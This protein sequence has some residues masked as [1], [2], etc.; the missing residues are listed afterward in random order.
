MLKEYPALGCCG[1][2][3]GLCPSYYTDGPSR[4][5]GCC[6]EDFF[7]KH[8]SCSFIT[9]CVKKKG[10]KVCAQCEDFPCTKFDHASDGP[11]FKTTSK[12][13]LQNQQYIRE[14]GLDKFIEQQKA[15]IDLLQDMLAQYNDGKAKTFY[16]LT[17]TLLSFEGL[18]RAFNEANN[19]VKE[20]SVDKDDLRVKARILKEALNQ[21]AE[22]ENEILK[23]RKK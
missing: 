8:P 16:C 4:C 14:F 1:L 19:Q 9:C 20:G 23:L 11:D 15:R 13:L 6:G 2:D 10:L 18:T 21:V 5:P 22:E 12:K 17:A 3:C 7:E